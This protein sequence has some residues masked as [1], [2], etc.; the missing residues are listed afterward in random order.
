[1]LLPEPV[2]LA[3]E[4]DDDVLERQLEQAPDSEAV[5]LIFA[6]EGAPYLARTARL[7]RRLRR[8]L[9]RAGATRVLALGGVA[10]RVE[11]WP[12]ASRFEAS[13]IHYELARR[14][15][16][17][18]Y[19]RIT[20]L[21]LPAYVKLGLANPYPRTYVTARTGGS[22]GLYYGP[23]RTRAAAEQFE[24]GVLDLFQIRRCQED[25]AP[26]PEHPGCIYGEMNMCLRPCQ[27][28][29]TAQEYGSEVRRISEFLSGNGTALL[30]SAAAARE[31]LSEEMEFEAAGREHKRYE[32][33]Q[34][35]LS[36]REP[37]TGNVLGLHGV[38]VL[39]SPQPDSVRL[40][41][42]LSGSWQA[43]VDFALALEDAHNVSL[44]QRLRELAAGIEPEQRPQAERQEHA[45]LLVRWFYSSWRDGEWIGFESLA[46][47]PYR[48]LVR[49]ISRIRRTG[50]PAHTS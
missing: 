27:G 19:L 6:E 2:S 43:P 21:R 10:R 47:L 28:S 16:P 24:A 38:A 14:Y 15:F 7:R 8:M 17:N 42:F 41:F 20:K 25:L 29:V 3:V 44:D 26:S 1:M 49:A 40:W 50:L 39:P 18:E 35:V 9:R 33:I 5:F 48:K 34:E 4:G 13:L 37:L 22:A 45:A 46:A 11:Y 30:Q 32:R 31:Q 12:V 23:F 36:R